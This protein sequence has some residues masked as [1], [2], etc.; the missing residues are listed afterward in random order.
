V[1]IP[2]DDRTFAINRQHARDYLNTPERLYCIDGFA[3]WDPTTSVKIQT[4]ASLS[5]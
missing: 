4:K 2:C 1:N 3:G 5:S